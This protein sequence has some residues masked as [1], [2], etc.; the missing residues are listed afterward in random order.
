MSNQKNK[1]QRVLIII[2][3]ILI[4]TG[5]IYQ[6]T[7][8]TPNI[9]GSALTIIVMI[10]ILMI[11]FI[12]YIFGYNIIK[13]KRSFMDCIKALPEIIKW[14]CFPKFREKGNKQA[15]DF[16][17][18]AEECDPEK[19]IQVTNEFLAKGVDAITEYNS[20]WNIALAYF[21]LDDTDKAV[22]VSK[23]LIAFFDTHKKVQRLAKKCYLYD[24]LASFYLR[25]GEDE[26]AKIYMKLRDEDFANLSDSERQNH[27]EWFYPSSRGIELLSEGRYEHA[28]SRQIKLFAKNEEFGH[29]SNLTNTQIHYDFA[30]IY[31][32]M[33]DLE[34]EIEHL[35]LVVVHGKKL[36]KAI[37]A[38]QRL[39]DLGVDVPAEVFEEEEK[40]GKIV[41][42]QP[43][44]TSIGTYL[45]L[46]L[47]VMGLWFLMTN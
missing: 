24:L 20:R 46:L 15:Q 25:I 38:R 35:R 2:I 22:E 13:N 36:K 6:L 28:L 1:F 32:K 11:L 21:E 33:G 16:K 40:M 37:D 43:R 47:I 10:G 31:E 34:K 18:L 12:I 14:L 23:E 29:M 42:K 8:E 19:Y 9:F 39:T 7:S 26:Q 41:E 45:I 4:F 17:I 44:K 30:K 27:E 3:Y 5:I